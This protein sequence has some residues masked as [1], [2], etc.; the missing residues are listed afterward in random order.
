MSVRYSLEMWYYYTAVLILVGCL[1]NPE[2][3][4]GA[5]S[6]AGS[7]ADRATGPDAAVAAEAPEPPPPL[8]TLWCF[9]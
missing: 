1:K 4:V 2:I 6:T 7:H 9:L 3:Q 8:T 5:I